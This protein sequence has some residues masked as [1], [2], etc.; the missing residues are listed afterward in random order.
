MQN[1]NSTTADC[2]FTLSPVFSLFLNRKYSSVL[3]SF[4]QGAGKERELKKQQED[5]EDLQ[6]KYPE[7]IPRARVFSM[8]MFPEYA[9][10]LADAYEELANYSEAQSCINELFVRF[11]ETVEGCYLFCDACAEISKLPN[12]RQVN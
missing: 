5:L 8:L 4:S 11:A 6:L 2:K 10:K 7:P 1:L 12:G 3:T 9:K